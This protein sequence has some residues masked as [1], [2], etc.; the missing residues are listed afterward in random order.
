MWLGLLLVRKCLKKLGPTMDER[1]KRCGE[2]Q[3]V[4]AGGDPRIAFEDFSKCFL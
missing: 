2:G 1:L 3:A 4:Q